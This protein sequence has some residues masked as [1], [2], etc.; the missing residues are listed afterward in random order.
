MAFQKGHKP[1]Y[2]WKGKHRS[3]KTKAKISSKL[4]GRKL[5]EETKKKMSIWAKENNGEKRFPQNQKGKN[6]PCW[7]GGCKRPYQHNNWRY[8]EW[9][10]K[11]F[12]R[13]NWTCQ[14]CG[15]RSKAGEPVYL[16]AHHIKGWSKYE[17]LRYE[18]SNGITLCKS[19]HKLVHKKHL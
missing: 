18:L 17:K 16:E 6:S 3:E 10:S 5:S 12:E 13:D 7:K 2:S 9:R 8:Y 15:A 19:C 14:T 4:T 11:V 1:L